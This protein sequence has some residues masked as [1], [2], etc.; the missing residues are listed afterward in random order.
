MFRFIRVQSFTLKTTFP[1]RI[2]MGLTGLTS[3]INY[4][5]ILIYKWEG[6]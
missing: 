5:I 3:P 6:G 2:I 1:Q 4:I